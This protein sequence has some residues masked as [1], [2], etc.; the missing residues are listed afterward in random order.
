MLISTRYGWMNEPTGQIFV[1]IAIAAVL[2]ASVLTA[3]GY[4]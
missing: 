2:F 3:L 1:A 4:T